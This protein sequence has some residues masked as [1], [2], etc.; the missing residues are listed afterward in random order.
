[1]RLTDESIIKKTS[2]ERPAPSWAHKGRSRFFNDRIITVVK[3]YK[4]DCEML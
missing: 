1:M 4:L 3:L 2:L